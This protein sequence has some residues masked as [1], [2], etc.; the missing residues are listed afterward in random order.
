MI[1]L[2]HNDAQIEAGE[3][4]YEMAMQLWVHG[5]LLCILSCMEGGYEGCQLDM[6][7][8]EH[9][10]MEGH[11]PVDVIWVWAIIPR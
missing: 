2:R 5:G 11:D 9:H 7:R 10:F 6:V 4:E 1:E 3:V 8:F